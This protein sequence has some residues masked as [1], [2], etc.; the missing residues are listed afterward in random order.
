MSEESR[1]E[2]LLAPEIV[3]EDLDLEGVSIAELPL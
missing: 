1:E 3:S 2:G